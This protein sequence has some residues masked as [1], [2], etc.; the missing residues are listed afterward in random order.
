MIS[1]PTGSTLT[2]V[3]GSAATTILTCRTA[4]S[5]G[6]GGYHRKEIFSTVQSNIWHKIII[7][8]YG[9]DSDCHSNRQYTDTCLVLYTYHRCYSQHCIQLK[10]AQH[11]AELEIMVSIQTS[12]MHF[13][14]L[15]NP[16][17]L[18]SDVCLRTIYQ[19]LINMHTVMLPQ[20]TCMSKS[21]L[22]KSKSSDPK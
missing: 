20:V 7:R 22:S 2:S 14:I 12:S 13:V 16:K 4:H 11:I 6:G 8:S 10:G 18:Q 19:K 21:L 17:R 1:T 15:S 5:C 3:G 9:F